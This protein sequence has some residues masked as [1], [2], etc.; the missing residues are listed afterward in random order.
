MSSVPTGR[1]PP[2][3]PPNATTL[4]S[5]QTNTINKMFAAANIHASPNTRSKKKPKN[6]TPKPLSKETAQ[7]TNQDKS[8]ITSDQEIELENLSN[9]QNPINVPSTPDRSP[10]QSDEDD[11]SDMEGTTN[12]NSRNNEDTDTVSQESEGTPTRK[13][14]N[15]KRRRSRG[16][17]GSK[18]S[19][20]TTLFGKER[21]FTP[22][23]THL[24]RFDISFRIEES[25][26]PPEQAQLKFQNLLRAIQDH[27]DMDAHILPWKLS[28]H[29]SFPVISTTDQVPKQLSQL[30]V[31][32]PR[33]RL[34]KKSSMVYTNMFIE[35]EMDPKDILLDI[36]FCMEDEGI[37]IFKKSIQA[38][39]V[40]IIGWFLYGIREIDPENLAEAI[41]KTDGTTVVG[42]R[43]MRIRTAI[44]GKA[45]PIRAMGIECDANYEE[46][47]KAQLIKLYQSSSSNWPLGIKLR[48]MRD[49]RF[50]CGTDALSKTIHLLG[51]HDR[52]QNGICSQR[53][54]DILELDFVNSKV[55][56][57]L[58]EIL[59]KIKSTKRPSSSLFHS[60]DPL[61]NNRDIHIFTF[62]PDFMDQAQSIIN[63]M[64][65]YLMHLEGDH[66][67]SY[68]TSEA[69]AR[70]DG[71]VWNEE[72]GCAISDVDR[73]LS[74]IDSLDEAY[75][76]ANPSKP[77][78]SLD[79]SLATPST[80]KDSD[81]L[82]AY[83]NASVSTFGTNTSVRPTADAFQ[84][85]Q[86]G[87]Q[88]NSSSV[89]SDLS[90]RTKSSI[91][92]AVKQD[93]RA[94]IQS[95]LATLLKAELSNFF[96]PSIHRSGS[97][98]SSHTAQPTTSGESGETDA[99][100]EQGKNSAGPSNGTGEA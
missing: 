83:D 37:K 46:S 7:H 100:Q 33:L 87:N 98:P 85:V 65:P 61:W 53:T 52:F 48:Y 9:T 58:R 26:N 60:V 36:S 97:N 6:T 45:S 23:G 47:A 73:E 71:C 35:H 81:A 67:R 72:R 1:R 82:F 93:L 54:K 8:P 28:D 76:I 14:S 12:C 74:R 32:F 18:K 38:E 59:M 2:G 19:V 64:V 34:T 99:S 78:N 44:N 66:V 21:R 3:R 40:A 24:T 88:S 86:I 49:V 69:L 90:F 10:Q 4:A 5:T 20:Q 29:N 15:A 11:I 68:F 63:Q 79:I 96:G 43:Q 42:L 91:I 55:K 16:S 41:R 84:T 70:S 30:R 31:Y 57:S 22:N 94:E 95:S 25:S 75:D 77:S 27:S 51:K 56:K 13:N 17:R 62:L 39:E 50:L 89:A 80:T 92:T